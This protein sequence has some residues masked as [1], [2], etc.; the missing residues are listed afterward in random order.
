M[1]YLSWKDQEVQVPNGMLWL[2]WHVV[3]TPTSVVTEV[4][5]LFLVARSALFDEVIFP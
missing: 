4:S 3:G 5:A 2:S 1:L